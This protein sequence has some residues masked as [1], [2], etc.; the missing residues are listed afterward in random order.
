MPPNIL[1]ITGDHVRADALAGTAGSV[2]DTGLHQACPLPALDRLCRQGNAFTHAFAANPICVPSRASITSGRYPHHCLGLKGN[3]GGILEGQPKVAEH[4]AAQGYRTC[5]IGKLHYLPYTPPNEPTVLHGFQHAE[6]CEEGRMIAKFG[7]EKG[8]EAYHDFMSEQGWG[9]YERS[10]GIGNNDVHPASVPFP[11]DLHEEA[12]VAQRA[13]AWMDTQASSD[14][15][16]LMWA[17]FTKP[18]PPYD[19]PAPYDRMIDP[20]HISAPFLAEMTD[21]ECMLRDPDVCRR[22]YQYGWDTLSPQALQ[23]IRAHYMGLMAFQDAMIGRMLEKLDALGIMDNTLIVYSSD[24]GD[25]LGDFGRFFKSCLFDAS[26]RIPLVIKPPLSAEYSPGS[27]D[28]LCSLIDLLPTF[29]DI[30]NIP[31]PEGLD[32]QSLRPVLQDASVEIRELVVT[33]TLDPGQ[34][35]YMLRTRRWKYCYHELGATEELYDAEGDYE[36]TN[37]AAKPE[38]QS[39]LKEFREHL[40]NWCQDNGDEAMLDPKQATGLAVTPIPE[41][42]ERAEIKPSNFGWRHY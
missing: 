11:A 2:S 32:G 40:R 18:H 42:Y 13:T 14:Q 9:G 15:P 36:K 28:Q 41:G 10:H 29:C 21:E 16:W 20:R 37:L 24:H 1:L 26:A 23:V 17:S 31:T 27:R 22:K 35:K 19:P 25:L 12:W 6:L 3:Y 38:M 7:R 8:Q 30:A 34:Q 4:F 33:Q 5:A 39:L